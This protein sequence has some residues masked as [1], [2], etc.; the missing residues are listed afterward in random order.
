MAK[1]GGTVAKKIRRAG[2]VSKCH[3]PPEAPDW[4]LN[5]DYIFSDGMQQVYS[6]PFIYGL[7]F[8]MSILRELLMKSTSYI[9]EL[10]L[11]C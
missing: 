4:T 6:M 9:E 10:K 1:E 7:L 5:K 11:N 8:Q 2:D 3:P